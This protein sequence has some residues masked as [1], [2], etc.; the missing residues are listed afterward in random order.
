MR[1]TWACGGLCNT[2]RKA[3][4]DVQEG[5]LRRGVGAQQEAIHETAD[6]ERRDEGAKKC[7]RADG[8]KI[9]GKPPLQTE[10]TMNKEMGPTGGGM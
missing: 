1:Q 10:S 2:S 6:E 7:K 5:A 9:P 3:A 8:P 4:K